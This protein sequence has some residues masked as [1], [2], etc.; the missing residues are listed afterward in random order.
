M[1][2][3][4]I[5]TVSGKGSTGSI[6]VDIANTLESMG[7]E[8]VI[9]YGHGE[10]NYKRTYKIGTLLETKF[11]SLFSRITG[12]QGLASWCSTRRF[13][14]YIKIYNPDIVHANNLHGNYLNYP[15]LLKYLTKQH[16]PLVWTMHD[17]WA[18]TGKC[19]HYIN[20]DCYKWK[21]QCEKCPNIKT[22]PPSLFLDTSKYVYNMRKKLYGNMQNVVMV[23]VSDWIKTE[24]QQSILSHFDIRRVYNWIDCDTFAPKKNRSKTL[25]SYG[26]SDNKFIVLGVCGRFSDA[27]GYQS[28]KY[29]AEHL[30]EEYMLILV[31]NFVENTVPKGALHISYINGI[32]E[33]SRL[34][35]AADVFC[36]LSSAE[37]F[38]KTTAESLAS[39][40]PVIV[41]NT[42]A[43]VELV[44]SNCGYVCELNNFEQV[45]EKIK[46]IHHNGKN[47]YTGACRKFALNNFS[48]SNILEFYNIYKELIDKTCNV[49]E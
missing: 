34:Y 38:G 25:Q 14:S 44:G 2:V 17:C 47:M 22:Y 31:G 40:T 18:Y 36:N 32:E 16:I 5:N 8:T 4:Q 21:T 43:C 39:G 48:K 7:V 30:S 27:K 26:V 6:C 29:I 3:L 12:L 15:M 46:L 33:L 42:S 28:W 1:K 24:A 11:H 35:S 13:I 10:P 49:K 45:V 41:Y 23:A 9:A 37:S 20:K 19:A